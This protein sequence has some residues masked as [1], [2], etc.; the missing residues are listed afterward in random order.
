MFAVN[1]SPSFLFL[2]PIIASRIRAQSFFPNTPCRT[3]RLPGRR[4]GSRNIYTHDRCSTTSFKDD[5]GKRP[6]P[7][8][9]QPALGPEDSKGCIMDVHGRP[10]LRGNL[11]GTRREGVWQRCTPR[12]PAVIPV[13][14]RPLTGSRARRT[15]HYAGSV[16]YRPLRNRPVMG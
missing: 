5:R 3:E 16:L 12:D 11:E 9:M 7:G 13:L 2:F 1:H 4:E 10:P 8:G 15:W 6:G 14:W